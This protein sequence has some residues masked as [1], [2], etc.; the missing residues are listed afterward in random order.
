[1]KKVFFTKRIYKNE[2]KTMKSNILILSLS[3]VFFTF[4]CDESENHSSYST[5]NTSTSSELSISSSEFSVSSSS[6]ATIENGEIS[7]ESF[8][9]DTTAGCFTLPMIDLVHGLEP[10]ISDGSIENT[11]ILADFSSDELHSAPHAFFQVGDK[12][13]FKATSMEY[14]EELYVLDT[15]TLEVVLL[16][17]ISEKRKSS[18]ITNMIRLKDKLFFIA[19]DTS[20]YVSDGT[21]MGTVKLTEADWFSKLITTDNWVYYVVKEN[22]YRTDGVDIEHMID[23][24]INYKTEL[25]S[26]N[27]TLLIWSLDDVWDR[28]ATLYTLLDDQSFFQFITS[29]SFLPSKLLVHDNFIYFTAPYLYEGAYTL[30]RYGSTSKKIETV[31][32]LSH[33]NGG[34][35]IDKMFFIND[36]FYALVTRE[37][38]SSSSV[39]I[40]GSDPIIY[41]SSRYN[42]LYS[43]SSSF[44]DKQ[45]HFFHEINSISNELTFINQNRNKFYFNTYNY[46]ISDYQLSIYDVSKNTKKI[47]ENVKISNEIQNS[48]RGTYFNKYGSLW[49][50]DYIS[51]EIEVV[52]ESVWD[53]YMDNSTLY[54]TTSQK[55]SELLWAEEDDDI[56]Q[57]IININTATQ[58]SAMLDFYDFNTTS[59][60]YTYDETKKSYTLWVTD[61]IKGVSSK[62]KDF[63][64]Y[65]INKPMYKINNSVYFVAADFNQSYAIYE[66]DLESNDIQLIWYPELSAYTDLVL[67]LDEKLYYKQFYKDKDYYYVFDTKRMQSSILNE[68]NPLIPVLQSKSFSQIDDT[69]FYEKNNSVVRLHVNKDMQ[70]NQSIFMNNVANIDFINDNSGG[71]YFISKVI[72][73]A[74]SKYG[75]SNFSISIWHSDTTLEKSEFL[76]TLKD[77]NFE[78]LVLNVTNSKLILNIGQYTWSENTPFSSR[79][80]VTSYKSY[81]IDMQNT[82]LELIS[83]NYITPYANKYNPKFIFSIYQNIDYRKYYVSYWWYNTS[84]REKKLYYETY[85][86]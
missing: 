25:W 11:K 6:V 55:G 43:F 30:R 13:Y 52:F 80:K 37:Y 65:R 81:I 72:E 26:L 35:N 63:G 49:R 66:V 68:D 8:E 7:F 1:M 45:V 28:S 21:P 17:D 84:T 24:E 12:I 85:L 40:Q 73:P 14:A 23:F 18:T 33:N 75:D 70:I 10:W 78:L 86:Y 61:F 42:A 29:L 60:F 82:N 50:I 4:G 27:D 62:I 16:K 77:K 53:F 48:D 54:M 31:L 5:Q 56:A 2:V 69:F 46:N 39:L 57:P 64:S 32:N 19:N 47:M 44:E 20:L 9:C 3:I 22:L 15:L 67:T 58:N 36:R 74:I 76:Y 79:K 41:P 38:F 51:D 83:D 59:F 34:D 71:F